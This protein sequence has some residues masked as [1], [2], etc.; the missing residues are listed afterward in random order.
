[1]MR[2]LFRT[3]DGYFLR[4][5]MR[6]LALG[7]L[8]AIELA[9][10]IENA[11][12]DADTPISGS[13]L[14]PVDPQ[15]YM[16][17]G[18]NYPEHA[19][20][21]GMPIPDQPVMNPAQAKDSAVPSGSLIARPADT[22]NFMDY[23]VEVGIVIGR[24]CADADEETA[25]QAILG[26]VPIL[27]LS[28]RDVLFRAILAMREKREGPAMADAKVF[29]ASKPFGPEM[30]L[31]NESMAQ[32]IDLP[33]SLEIN[34]RVRQA[35][36]MAKM[37]FPPAQLVAAASK[38]TTLKA[39]DVICSGTPAGVGYVHGRFLEEGDELVARLGELQPLKVTIS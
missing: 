6:T 34:G 9:D 5:G 18:L 8:Q 36:T 17:V 27:D 24:N 11:N 10:A 25:S 1:M 38:L 32:G 35:S 13:T 14:P 39:G 31:W 20:E 3:T 2:T 4:D 21:G 26:L 30:L 28:L 12:V 19:L 7:Q 23:E 22:P 15:S 33:L 29:T 16:L 37:I